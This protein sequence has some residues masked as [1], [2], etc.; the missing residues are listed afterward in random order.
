MIMAVV[1][2]ILLAVFACILIWSGN[3]ATD[4]L[5]RSLEA[6]L[7]RTMGAD[8]KPEPLR[9]GGGAPEGSA[10]WYAPPE[11]GRPPAEPADQPVAVYRLEGASLALAPRSSALLDEAGM[12][13]AQMACDAAPEGFGSIPALGLSFLKRFA[14][15]GTYVAFAVDGVA[16][17][18]RSLLVI[19]AGVGAGALLIFLVAAVLFSRWALRPVRTAWDQQRTFIANASHELK[20]P[21]AIIKANTEVL[22][23]EPE[24][25]WEERSHWLQSTQSA[26]DGMTSL[27]EDLLALASLDERVQSEGRRPKGDQAAAPLDVS[28]L[29]EGIVLGFESRAVEGGFT[30]EADIQEGVQERLDEEG[31][32]RI[33]NVLLDNAC[34]YVSPGGQVTVRFIAPKGGEAVLK[35]ANTGRTLT[36]EEQKRIFERFYRSAEARSVA[37]G[38]GLGLSIAKALADQMG[39]RLAVS[40]AD[41]LTM[42][43]LAFPM[44]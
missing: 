33:A 42:F 32:S 9:E 25:P 38:H 34:K 13:E 31:L 8:G 21:L 19:F 22:L 11:L 6:A 36:P 40:S 44:R 23:E 28:R 10:E 43:S 3:E 27:A 41:G 30:L 39:A 1:A 7:N 4:Q 15:G 12:E 17:N 35:V 29:L 5:H 2:V 16:E 20:T 14:G 18:Q 37:E 26:A 24:A